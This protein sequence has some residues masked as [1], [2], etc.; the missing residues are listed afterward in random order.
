[1]LVGMHDAAQSKPYLQDMQFLLLQEPM[2]VMHEHLGDFNS[3][4]AEYGALT[5]ALEVRR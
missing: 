1:M 3:Q 2:A 5:R 4:Q